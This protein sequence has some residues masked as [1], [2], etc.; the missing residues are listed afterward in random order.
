MGTVG[1]LQ[2]FWFLHM[3]GMGLVFPYQS[4]YFH[5]NIGLQG[6]QLGLLLAVRPLMGMLFQPIWGHVS[7]RSGSRTQVLALLGI[8]GAA[9]HALLPLASQFPTLLLAMALA[10]AFGTSILPVATSVSMAALGE[11]AAERFGRVRVWGTLGFLVMV[12][13][14]PFVLDRIQRIRGWA[15]EPGGP[16]EPG[17]GSIFVMA[18]ALGLAAALVAAR[19]P[20]A[21]AM[22]LRSQPGDLGRLLRHGPFVRLLVFTFFAYFFLQGPIL[23]FPVFIRAHGGTIDTLSRMWIPMLLLEIPLVF[24]LGPTLK[25][26]GAR[27]L[28]AIGVTADGVRWLACALSGELW[29][30]YAFQLLHGVVVAGLIIGVSLYVEVVVPERLRST[31]QGVL[32]M[33]GISL[34]SML[35]SAHCGLLLERLGADAPYLV[36]GAG[37]LLLALT[38]PWLLPRP[39]RP[40]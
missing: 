29:V 35:S 38:I 40:A 27:G 5:E 8:A 16:S 19:L 10:S 31:G 36:G 7:D 11:N 6:A 14:F 23:L 30:M 9:G 28:L 2:L 4:L 34:A 20:R 25:R 17:L 24:L 32:A 22:S 33:V 13:G 3:A 18:A 21:G 15:S 26:V 1:R 37:A 39:T 12:V